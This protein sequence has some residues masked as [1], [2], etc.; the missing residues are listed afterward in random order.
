MIV[1][2]N[3]N[4]LPIFMKNAG[5]SAVKQNENLEIIA[6]KRF[7]SQGPRNKETTPLLPFFYLNIIF[8][9]IFINKIR[10]P[11]FFIQY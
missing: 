11:N 8:Y 4:I 6:E 7:L 1:I 5:G 3:T 9:H 2:R 10:L